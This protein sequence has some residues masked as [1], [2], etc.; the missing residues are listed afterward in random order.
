MVDSISPQSG[1]RP[2]TTESVADHETIGS[3][4]IVD[5]ESTSKRKRE[6]WIQIDEHR[7]APVWLH[8]EFW[9]LKGEDGKP[10]TKY[11][12]CK[13]CREHKYKA[14][15]GYGTSNAS[16]H[17]KSCQAYLKFVAENP[18][19]G[20]VFDQKLN[21]RNLG[22]CFLICNLRCNMFLGTLF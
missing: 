14:S 12:F 20:A 1:S 17:L 10:D 4:I 19:S 13:Y 2:P 15:S 7:R 18:H 8:Y 22:L 16:I 5:P 9:L 21:M 3:N 11:A 6:E